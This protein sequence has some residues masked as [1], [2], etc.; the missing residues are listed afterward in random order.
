MTLVKKELSLLL[1]TPTVIAYLFCIA[2]RRYTVLLPQWLLYLVVSS[3]LRAVRC[4]V[5]Y[6]FCAYSDRAIPYGTDSCVDF[7][8][9][10]LFAD[11]LDSFTCRKFVASTLRD[12]LRNSE[13]SSGTDRDD[14]PAGDRARTPRLYTRCTVGSKSSGGRSERR[15]ALPAIE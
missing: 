12:R 4:F 9:G 15:D 14:Q 13:R 6:Y 1:A 7:R 3:T 10:R 11:L 2:Y 8:Y 5:L